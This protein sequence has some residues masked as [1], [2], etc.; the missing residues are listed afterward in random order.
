[1]KFKFKPSEIKSECFLTFFIRPIKV[2]SVKTLQLW[3]FP[4]LL[5]SVF[6]WPDTSTIQW[7]VW[8]TLTI[9]LPGSSPS[10]QGTVPRMV[11]LP[12][13]SGE[14]TSWTSKAHSQDVALVPKLCPPKFTTPHIWNASHPLPT[15]S[16]N[17]FHLQS[18]W[19]T[20]RT[21]RIL[22]GITITIGHRLKNSFQIEVQNPEEPIFWLKESRFSHSVT[23]STKLTIWMKHSAVSWI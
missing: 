4:P 22:C 1:M 13:K 5:T 9:Q 17:L 21:R 8:S 11:R 14:I 6:L 2:F 15:L 7:T 19:I 16:R 23:S 10:T 20:S 12:S 3:K 18:P